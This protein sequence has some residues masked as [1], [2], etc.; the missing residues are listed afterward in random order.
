M[1][2]AYHTIKKNHPNKIIFMQ[3][4]GFYEAYYRDAIITERVLSLVM[5]RVRKAPMTCIPTHA[6]EEQFLELL[7]NGYEL[8]ICSPVTTTPLDQ[9]LDAE[10]R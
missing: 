2:T 5:H 1:F 4:G 3:V 9:Y 8:A 6:A 10:P 7:D